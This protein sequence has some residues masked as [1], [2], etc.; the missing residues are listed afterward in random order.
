MPSWEELSYFLDHGSHHASLR[1]DADLEHLHR[2]TTR[3]RDWPEVCALALD[4]RRQFEELADRC[5]VERGR[6]AT[7]KGLIAQGAARACDGATFA[8]A[9]VDNRYGSE[10][11][12]S[13]TER[14][15]WLARPV[16]RPG[17]RPLAF[18][19]SRN[20]A[21]ELREWP[22]SQIAKCLLYYHPDE[23]EALRRHQED[24]LATLHEACLAT[25]HELLVELI[26][27][28]GLPSDGGTLVRALAA[29][30]DRGIRPDWW[31]LPPPADKATWRAIAALLDARDPHCRGIVLLGLN[32]PEPELQ[33]AFELAADERW[34]KGFAVGRTI[35]QNAAEEWF[36]G[37]IDDDAAIQTI[38]QNY[39]RLIQ[40][41]QRRGYGFTSTTLSKSR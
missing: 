19:A 15:W 34:C 11:L 40:L 6:I 18:E 23:L 9:I 13:L 20:I 35:F 27:P 8:G 1:A 29:L 16:E 28:S 33:Q 10:V 30:Y 3:G 22:E 37:K 38:A 32:A 24:M 12:A 17:S 39:S 4:H 21:L 31:K 36:A 5:G 25:R 14:G 2:A 41:W 7:F 26:L